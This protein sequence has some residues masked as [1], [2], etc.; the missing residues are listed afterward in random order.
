MQCYTVRQVGL[1]N[2]LRKL[3]EQHVYW[4]RFFIISTAAGLGDLE[5]VTARLLQN[6][7]DFAS[8][9]TPFYPAKT[10]DTFKALFTQH[11]LI[12][13]DLVNA[14]KNQQATKVDETRKKWYMNAD[15]I[16]K[17]L[18]D[19]NPCWSNEK[20]KTMLYDHLEMTEKEALLRLSEKYPKDIH[21]FETIENDALKM[22]DYMSCGIIRQFSYR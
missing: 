5:A 10:V 12:G 13:G 1:M 8:A 11:L 21:I 20:W 15:E 3:W 9:L 22:A 18:A 2:Q 4:T 14:A 6:P 17:F 19:I 16:A 7:G